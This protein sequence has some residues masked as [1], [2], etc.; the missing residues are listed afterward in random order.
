[1]QGLTRFL[2]DTPLRVAIRLVLL[3]F[4]VGLILS[5]LGLRPYDIYWWVERTVRHI[6]DMGWEFF[7]S[8]L[9]YLIAGALIVVPLFIISRLFKVG[10]RR[11]QE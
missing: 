6:Y 5:A 3:S 2:G 10:G 9:D 8:S 11:R 7:T 4:V 1:M